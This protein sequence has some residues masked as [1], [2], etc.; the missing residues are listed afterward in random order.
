MML[1]D[2]PEALDNEL[3]DLCEA[4]AQEIRRLFTDAREV[5][6]TSTS[7]LADDLELDSL[8]LVELQAAVEDVVGVEFDIDDELIDAFTTV[9]TLARFALS[10]R[11]ESK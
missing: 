1:T 11:E 5:P 2:R 6:I 9:G 10:R 8:A 4:I 3:G 7:R